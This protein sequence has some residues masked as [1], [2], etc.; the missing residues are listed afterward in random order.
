MLISEN[1]QEERQ[2]SFKRI[3]VLPWIDKKQVIKGS[4]FVLREFSRY[5]QM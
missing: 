2:D 3:F 1:A 5:Y 4:Q